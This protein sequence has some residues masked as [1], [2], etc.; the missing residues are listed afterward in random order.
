MS[1]KIEEI[2]KNVTSVVT[3][4]MKKALGAHKDALSKENGGEGGEGGEGGAAGGEGGTKTEGETKTE[5]G[6]GGAAGGEG[7]NGEGAGEGGDATA[8]AL[9]EV[10]GAIK[11]LT[12][13]M[14]DKDNEEKTAKAKAAQE[15]AEGEMVDRVS[16]AV[17]QR[18]TDELG[19]EK[20]KSKGQLLDEEA[21]DENIDNFVKNSKEADELSD[22]EL[23][24]GSGHFNGLGQELTVKQWRD[25][26]RL[27]KHVTS[28]IE[29]GF[30]AKGF[31]TEADDE[32]DDE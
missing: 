17:I 15:K 25:R 13:R 20:K 9:K 8:K 11:T 31:D 16:K 30:K 26:Q 14:D 18:I 2:L 22:E 19:G 4:E 3:E 21:T 29:A 12:K 23:S 10:T 1:K 27:A 6:E 32:D 28:K 7:G 5:G 24:T